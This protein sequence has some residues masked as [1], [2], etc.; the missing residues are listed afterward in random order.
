MC[1]VEQETQNEPIG[2]IHLVLYDRLFHMISGA[3]LNDMMVRLNTY[4]ARHLSISSF[5]TDITTLAS[6]KL[7]LPSTATRAS[8]IFAHFRPSIFG[9]GDILLVSFRCISLTIYHS[10]YLSFRVP[11]SFPSFFILLKK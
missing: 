1:V 7:S 8:S 5:R 9:F 10:L 11:N 6:E 3:N 2:S 4:N